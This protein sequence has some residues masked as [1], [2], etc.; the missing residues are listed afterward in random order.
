MQSLQCLLLRPG[1]LS[2]FKEPAK[3]IRG[4]LP[5]NFHRIYR[6]FWR[7]DFNGN[8]KCH[9]REPFKIQQPIGK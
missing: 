1:R 5:D 6:L 7:F 9:S 2:Y 8:L 4:I 3:F